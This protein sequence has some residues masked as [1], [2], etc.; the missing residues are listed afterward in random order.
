MVLAAR[1]AALEVRLHPG[2]ACVGVDFDELILD[3]FVEVLEALLTGEL[4]P[5]GTKKALQDGTFGLT[6]RFHVSSLDV[7]YRQAG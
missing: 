1:R 3:V 2:N 4:R 5:R 6:M 7:L